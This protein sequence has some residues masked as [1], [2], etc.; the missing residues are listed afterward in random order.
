MQNDRNLEHDLFINDADLDNEFVTY[1]G[2]LHYWLR[3]LAHAEEEAEDA[4][5]VYKVKWDEVYIEKRSQTIKGEKTVKQL[6][7][8]TDLDPRVAAAWNI[9]NR[10]KRNA[11]RMNAAVEAIRSKLNCLISLGAK[12]RAEMQSI[13]PNIRMPE[14][15]DRS[16]YFKKNKPPE[17]K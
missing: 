7:V 10:M 14:M 4:H 13:E 2:I 3:V 5:R 17:G 8:E 9:D 11:R 1:P 15:R 16:S 6:E 12:K